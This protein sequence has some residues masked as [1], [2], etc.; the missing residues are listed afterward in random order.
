MNL[1][2]CSE[3]CIHQKDGYCSCDHAGMVPQQS[4]VPH[5]DCLYFTEIIKAAEAEGSLSKH[6]KRLGDI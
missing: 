5:S 4:A 2:P 1:I 3:R 6:L